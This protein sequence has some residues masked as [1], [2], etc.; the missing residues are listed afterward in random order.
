[1]LATEKYSPKHTSKSPPLLTLIAAGFFVSHLSGGVVLLWT[2]VILQHDEGS[3]CVES[4]ATIT[5][6]VII[7]GYVNLTSLIHLVLSS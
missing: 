1:M 2:S 7:E 3:I 5:M 4:E 6:E